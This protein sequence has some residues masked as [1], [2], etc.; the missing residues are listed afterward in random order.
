MTTEANGAT[1]IYTMSRS[2][3]AWLVSI[4]QMYESH[5]RWIRRNGSPS[6]SC[7]K[8]V[9]FS[10]IFGVVETHDE[11][12]YSCGMMNRVTAVTDTAYPP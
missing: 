2:G 6:A 1:L 3:G 8:V 5:T 10:G 4:L 11:R 7:P 12:L 9:G